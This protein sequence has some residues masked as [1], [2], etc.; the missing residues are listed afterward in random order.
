MGYVMLAK[1]ECPYCKAAKEIFEEE[2]IEVKIYQADTYDKKN[3]FSDKKFK[4]RYGKNATYPRIYKNGN[5]IGGY[6]ELKV[7]FEL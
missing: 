6:N 2:N 4:K 5:L 7:H 3:D 1:P